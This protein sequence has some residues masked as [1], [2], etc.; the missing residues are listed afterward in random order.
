MEPTVRMATDADA[1]AITSIY[2]P[3]VSDTHFSF[4]TTP[5]TAT[6]MAR[7]IR[8]TTTQYPWLVCEYDGQIVGYAYAS[9]HEDRAAYQWS[10]DVSVYVTDR[11]QRHGVARGLYESLFALLRLQGYIFAYAVIA[12]PNPSSVGFHESFGFTRLAVYQRAGFKQGAWHDVGHWRASIQDHETPPSPP[13]PIDALRGTEP[14]TEAITTGES[15]IR[16]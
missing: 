9:A 7:R 13:T 16:M 10:V 2:S 1:D 11:S 15:S 12:L 8:D 4:E 5:P 14:F 3:I 6:E